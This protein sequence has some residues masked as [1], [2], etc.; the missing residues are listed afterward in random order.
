[1]VDPISSEERERF[2]LKMKL[3]LASIIAVSAGLIALRGNASL[4]VIAAAIVGGGLLGVGLIWFVF[5]DTGGRSPDEKR[6]RF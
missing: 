3:G 1:M 6:E 2:A 4:P 5:P